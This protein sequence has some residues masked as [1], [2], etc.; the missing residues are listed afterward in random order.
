MGLTEGELDATVVGEDIARLGAYAVARHGE[1][2]LD[3][4]VAAY[5]RLLALRPDFPEALSNLGVALKD[6]GRIEEA[7]AAF[8][9]ATAVRPDYAEAYSNLGVALKAAGRLDDAVAACR[10]A[11]RLAPHRPDMHNNLGVVLM[12]RGLAEDAVACYRLAL[13]IAPD[14][15]DSSYNLGNALSAQGDIAGAAAAYRQASVLRPEWFEAVFNLGICLGRLGMVDQAAR[16]FAQAAALRPDDAEAWHSLGAT[17]RELGDLVEAAACLR[18]AAS[19]RPHHVETVHGLAMALAGLGQSA[20]AL[21]LCR[22]FVLAD[23]GNAKAWQ[24]FAELLAAHDFGAFGEADRG[25]LVALLGHPNVEPSSVAA[26][27]LSALRADPAIS[28]LLR[29]VQSADLAADLAA[30]P[31]AVV[32]PLAANPLLRTLLSTIPIPDAG[33]ERLLAELRRALLAA[34]RGL[35]PTGAALTF[36]VSLAAQCFLNEYVYPEGADETQAVQRLERDIAAAPD[37]A[38]PLWLAVLAA[39][40]PLYRMSWAL[41]LAEGGVPAELAGLVRQQVEQPLAEW[42]LS[43]SVIALTGI[44]DDVSQAV[45]R[46]YDENPYPRWTRLGLAAERRSL[47]ATIRSLPGAAG[48]AV[49]P[50]R[51]EVLVA[52]CGTGRQAIWCADSYENADI[53]AVDLSLTSLCYAMRQAAAAGFAAI[54]FCQ[55]DILELP[56][57]G[58]RFDVI[59]SVGV[60]HHMRDPVAGWRILTEMLNPGGLMKIGLYSELGRNAVAAGRA[61]ARERGYA[62]VPADIRRFRQDVQ[63]LTEANPGHPASG[64]ARFHDFFTLSECRDLVFHVQEHRFTLAQI[65][66]ALPR[67]GLRFLG[68]ELASSP[69]AAAYR[70]RFPEDCAMVDLSNWSR[71]E[72]DNPAT[73][74][75]MYQF[76]V[77]KV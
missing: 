16:A 58:R 76:W 19:L 50:G 27:V 15:A 59:E 22:G 13:I 21:A 66:A 75:S 8:R 47:A 14:H 33:F 51:I 43:P 41:P 71:F 1:G 7:I 63:E 35:D 74:A 6:L 2:A 20:E 37:Q 12:E 5:R 40:R 31:A 26:A 17:R 56:A 9:Q 77:V 57:L 68:F 54:D 10:Q 38:P 25:I 61:L 42:L 73:F 3:D 46:H 69:V 18:R 32:A 60:L 36:C 39:Y 53:L 28:D 72:A 52:G 44:V 34:V 65:A 30:D 49:P 67:L 24:S 64:L 45:R 11:A 55:A 48:V 23:P 29:R 4:A 62:A 70:R